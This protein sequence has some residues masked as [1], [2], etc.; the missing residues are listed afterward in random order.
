M[1][2]NK[3]V[4]TR[5]SK[6]ALIQTGNIIKE[7]SSY[8]E[9][10][11]KTIKI[12]TK[13]DRNT[14]VSLDELGG[15]GIFIG[16]LEA[17]LLKKEADFAVHSMK[18]L[19]GL[20][21]EHLTLAAVAK[22]EDPRDA[23]ISRYNEPLKELK[24]GAV[25]GTSSARRSAQIKALRPDLETEWIRGPID[26]RIEQLKEGKF[27]AI[28]LAVAGLNRMNRQA[29][30]TEYLDISECVP[31]VAQGAIAIQC[32]K[33]DTETLKLL[34]NLNHPETARA[35]AIEKEILK[36]LDQDETVPIGVYADVSEASSQ[37][38]VYASVC[39]I[40]G[41][42]VIRSMQTGENPSELVLADLFK[43]GAKELIKQA[44]QVK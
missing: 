14:R 3:K 36:A 43:Q 31:A 19:D 32:R 20:M 21:D 40:D 16:D 10:K 7:L 34:K 2:T 27:D 42:K 22:R 30:I 1:M 9:E 12:S 5:A 25:I 33:D 38:T 28:I 18:D 26:S 11:I 4:V 8:T 37:V 44:K 13:G 39:S 35:V 23:L 29:E 24:P 17:M 6:L 15:R 41:K